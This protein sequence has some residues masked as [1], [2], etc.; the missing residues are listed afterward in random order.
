MVKT[1]GKKMATSD[2]AIGLVDL[3][4]VG[5]FEQA[6]KQYYHDDIVSVEP[7][8]E[9]PTVTGIDAVLGKL[10]YFHDTMDIHG[11][12]VTGPFLNGN[13]FAVRFVLDATQKQSGKRSTMEEI[14]VYTVE[15][16]K[17]VHEAFYFGS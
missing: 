12:E 15:G 1:K 17:I 9:T 4:K 3:C 11:A 14:G 7:M 6:I 5:S 13:Q 16:D 8:G 10:A 2:I